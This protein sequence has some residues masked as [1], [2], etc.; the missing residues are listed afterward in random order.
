MREFRTVLA[1]PHMQL[2]SSPY[3]GLLEPIFDIRNGQTIRSRSDD[4]PNN[5]L[6]F[7]P[8]SYSDIVEKFP[9]G[10]LVQLQ[11]EDNQAPTLPDTD[12]LFAKFI[13]SK[14]GWGEPDR[15]A[16]QL[17]VEHSFDLSKRTIILDEAPKHPIW[18]RDRK[19]KR[20][21]G[22]FDTAAHK[23]PT[24]EIA[25]DLLPPD[26]IPFAEDRDVHTIASLSMHAVETTDV[27]GSE[28]LYFTKA[29][30][31]ERPV[32]WLDFSTDESILDFTRELIAHEV[33]LTAGQLEKIRDL[34][35]ST[36]KPD[37]PFIPERVKRAAAL[38]EQVSTWQ[39]HRHTLIQE[40]LEAGHGEEFINRYLEAHQE[41]LIDQA[42]QKHHAQILQHVHDHTV[43]LTRLA[44]EIETHKSEL[45][46]LKNVD[47]AAL[48]A[49][50]EAL[51]G[52]LTHL[53]QAVADLKQQLNAGEE[54]LDLVAELEA[55]TAESHELSTKL[56][57]MK[58]EVE[59]L[60]QVSQRLRDEAQ[61]DLSD[62][63]SRL[64]SIKPYVDSLTG[65]TV[66]SRADSDIELPRITR[67]PAPSL[68]GLVDRMHQELHAVNHMIDRRDVA[69]AIT[70]IL[71]SPL[72]IFAGLP[73]VGKTSLITRLGETLGLARGSQ[74]LTIRVPRGWRSRQDVLGY[75]NPIT[76]DYERAPTGLYSLL[77]HQTRREVPVP[78]WVLFDEANLSAPEHYL[79]DFLGMMD[80]AADRTL[81][82]GAPGE[83]F[84]V[85]RHVRF[86]FT[87]NQDHSVEALTPR[88]MDRAAVIYVPPPD[89][90]EAGNTYRD[91]NST[92]GTFTVEAMDKMMSE[93]PSQLTSG[94][95]NTLNRIIRVLHDPDV[96]LG[97][98]TRISPR[99][100][101][102]VQRH[103]TTMRH[104]LG[105]NT[106]LDGLDYAVAAHIL[107]LVRGSGTGY[108]A[109]L[110][111]LARETESLKV[112]HSLLKRILTAGETSFD[113]YSFQTLA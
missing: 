21:F 53:K 19:K 37:G 112:S 71:T 11:I 111:A 8:S 50:R 24:G 22:P 30:F 83:I 7:T 63:T 113:E 14:N 38:L 58:S 66:Q 1:V 79:S 47:T 89:T 86:I 60:Q 29:E 110:N 74:F 93:V 9:A 91:V 102:R 40:Y 94:E 52:E 81:A 57:T 15:W 107:P 85:P 73:G 31:A 12:P 10:S 109:R 33:P 98:P 105:A 67:Q 45:E 64:T 17:V 87:I 44:E 104:I 51:E 49:N 56:Q 90:F 2:G 43:S 106:G 100:H 61:R 62:L 23:L 80:E 72:A 59:G 108:R 54:A 75:H 69:N 48:H 103:I 95:T 70:G 26:Q 16:V 3:I 32:D 99:K 65:G 20:F 18:L 42:F 76:G 82:T 5:G 97:T 35:A 6:I 34:L 41:Q 13:I 36:T 28:Y 101:R 46:Q 96:A 25:V 77:E 68:S 84:E 92:D 78:A 4:Y 39:E 27:A 88:V 55:K